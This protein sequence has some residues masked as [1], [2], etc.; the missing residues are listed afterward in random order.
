[1]LPSF[2]SL[3]NSFPLLRRQ[4]VEPLQLVAQALLLLLRQSAELRVALQSLFLLIEWRVFVLVQPVAGV[5]WSR[6]NA[7]PDRRPRYVRSTGWLIVSLV[8]RVPSR[9]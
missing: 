9:L 8:K 1:M 6:H 5:A 2:H 3:H 7:L 4:A